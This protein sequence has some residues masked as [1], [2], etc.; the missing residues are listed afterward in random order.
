M[1]K[2]NITI[3]DAAD[4]SNKSVQTIRRAIKANKLKHRRKQTPQGFNYVVNKVSLCELYGI[5][6]EEPEKEET[7]MKEVEETKAET[8]KVANTEAEVNAENTYITTDDFQSFTK[9]LEKMI[10][11]HAD[12]RQNFLRLVNSLQEKIFVLENQLNLLGSPEKKWFH[13]WK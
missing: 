13:F 4:L 2:E 10:S 11:Q 9:T 8:K 5:K 7:V 3:Q 6:I 1:S 12:E